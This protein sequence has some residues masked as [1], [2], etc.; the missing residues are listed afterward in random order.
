M[1]MAMEIKMGKEL[2]L[3]RPAREY[4]QS[5]EE[6]RKE[7]RSGVPVSTYPFLDLSGE[8]FLAKA[9]DF[10]QGKELPKG[11]VPATY[12]WLADET[13]FWGEVS[14]R[15]ELTDALLQFGGNVGYWVRKSAWGRGSGTEMLRQTL[16]YIG[17]YLALDSVLLTCN[18]ENIASARII[19]KNGGI[20]QDKIENSD[21]AGTRLTR[22]YWISVGKPEMEY[23]NGEGNLHE[24][25]ISSFIATRCVK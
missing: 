7:Y 11:W 1:Q 8:E 4:L 10:E 5:Y 17:E 2:R 9:Q 21:R 12:L 19:E 6:A 15:H 13:E 16:A 23:T 20:L 14:I 3:I 22:R 25:N 24:H 18:D